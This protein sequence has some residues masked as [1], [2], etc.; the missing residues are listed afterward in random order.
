M[1]SYHYNKTLQDSGPPWQ[2][3]MVNITDLEA[4]VGITSYKLF[5]ICITSS[6]NGTYVINH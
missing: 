2:E 3:N 5:S 1:V 6:Y 4:K